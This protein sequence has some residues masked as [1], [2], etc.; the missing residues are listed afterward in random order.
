MGT[1]EGMCYLYEQWPEVEYDLSTSSVCL[2]KEGVPL[3]SRFKISQFGVFL[4]EIMAN[5][6]RK[7]NI[8]QSIT[9]YVDWTIT[10][11]P[12]NVWKVIDERLKKTGI[13][14]D[15]AANH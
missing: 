2:S 9:E 4:L 11:Y 8:M 13:T 15:Q 10:N 14:E 7:N 6:C 5:K 1:L 12:E 3:I